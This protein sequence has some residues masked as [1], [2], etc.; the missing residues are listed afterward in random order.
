MLC[1]R[2]WVG[3]CIGCF[4]IYSSYV[5]VVSGLHKVLNY[6]LVDGL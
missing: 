2:F 6:M 5:G 1:D 4:G 3:L